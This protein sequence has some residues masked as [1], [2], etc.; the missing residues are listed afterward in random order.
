[1]N[2][3]NYITLLRIVLVPFFVN[4]MVYHYFREALIVF[5][6]ACFT[7][8]LD[9]LIA[10][11][12]KSKT[13]IGAFLDPT[14]DK[15]LITS[16]VITLAF[17]GMMPIWLAII[18]VSRDLILVLGG[19]VLYFTGHKFV[20]TPSWIGK[21][22]TAMQLLSVVL[23][24]VSRSFVGELRVTAGILVVTAAVTVASGTQYVW[25]GIKMVGNAS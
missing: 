21:S 1:M 8:A 16:A 10:R 6:A 25:R 2:L 17:M 9:G 18:V 23:L 13:V 20:A 7:D 19:L 11:V 15:L 3:P 24:L 4:L 14:A 5:V 12:T 22:T